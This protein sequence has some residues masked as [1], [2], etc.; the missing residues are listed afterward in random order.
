VSDGVVQIQ[1]SHSDRTKLEA[2]VQQLLEQRL[3]ACGQVLGPISSS[4]RWEGEVQAAREWLALL[5]TAAPLAGR[6][7]ARIAELHPYEV[8]EILVTEVSDGHEAYLRWVV[9]ETG[10]SSPG[11]WS[12]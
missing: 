9:R 3:I 10:G 8:P 7:S 12:G 5:K 1:V 2:I 4:F 6:V 11:V